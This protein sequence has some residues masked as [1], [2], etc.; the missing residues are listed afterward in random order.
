MA[1]EINQPVVNDVD[2]ANVPLWKKEFTLFESKN[3]STKERMFLFQQMQLLLQT[4][5]PLRAGLAAL[6]KQE[7]KASTRRLLTSLIDSIDQGKPFSYALSR[8]PDV[9]STTHI[10]LISASEEGGYMDKVLQQIIDMEERRATLKDTLISA[11]SYPLFLATFSFAVVVFIL[12][13]VFPKFSELFDKIHEHLPV[14]TKFLMW[15]SEALINNWMIVIGALIASF[16]AIGYWLSSDMGKR[17]LDK[18]KLSLPLVKNIF[19]QVYLV[20]S[21]RVMYLSLSNGVTIVDTLNSCKNTVQNKIYQEFLT[22]VEMKV[23]E[24][25]GISNGFS[26]AQFVPPLVKQMISTG[27]DTGNLPVVMGKIADHYENELLKYLKTLSK[28]AEP[29]MLVV[30]GA[31]VG[32]IVSSLILPI[33]MLSR[34]VN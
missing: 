14:T 10:N 8:F 34:A 11:I 6:K 9:F 16:V 25:N 21:L 12:V 32:I 2:D 28:L 7:E 22:N 13:V 15:T 19:T 4:G 20:Q 17:K 29:I 5:T 26:E 24:G 30:M 18:L 23:Q 31:V 27:E 1:L 33:F 3:V